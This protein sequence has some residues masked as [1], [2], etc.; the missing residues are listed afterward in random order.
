MNLRMRQPA[1][2]ALLLGTGLLGALVAQA[3][4][5]PIPFLLGS[6]VATAALALT[7]AA[8]TGKAM[9]FPV[10]LRAIFIGMIGA[11]IGTTFTPDVVSLA[12]ALPITLSA[13]VAFVL[14]ALGANYAIFRHLGGYDR[15]TATY[16]AM[17]GGLIESVEIGERAGADTVTLSIQHFV[18]IVLV[19][20]TVPL[21]FLAVT[22]EAVGSAA[23]QTLETS[24]TGWLD[25]ALVV[26]LAL[27]GGI[28]GKRLR[29]PA[30]AL[31]G[32]LILTAGMQATGVIDVEGP[33]LLLNA[34]QLVVG[35]SLGARFSTTTPRRLLLAL[36]LGAVSTA[37]TLGI[38]SLM[39]LALAPLVPISF[40][41][42]LISFSPGGVTEMS[43]I[44]LSIGASPVL[45][46]VHHLFRIL[47]AVAV[48]GL[49][50]R[51]DTPS[52]D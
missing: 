28:L 48:A 15:P 20:V 29:L 5:L 27:A 35:A 3:V 4:G 17:P 43:L 8:R 41:T 13:M 37:V 16:A 39:S 2:L 34:A 50:A 40:Q 26:V 46:S 14:M 18:R 21:L 49:T 19:I 24:A 6:L 45:V 38:A 25:W 31:I 47:F 32:P 23:G 7:L 33:Q 11:M 36:G 52:G 12:P 30:A 51:F 42:L 1:E 44:A 22:G 9:G 10:R